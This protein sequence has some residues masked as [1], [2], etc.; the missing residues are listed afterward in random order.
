MFSEEKMKT[1]FAMECNMGIQLEPLREKRV[2]HGYLHKTVRSENGVGHDTSASNIEK[3][4]LCRTGYICP[5][6]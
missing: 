2:G 5:K 1:V 3:W 4:N 6:Q